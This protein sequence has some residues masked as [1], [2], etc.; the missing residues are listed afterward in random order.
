MIEIRNYRQDDENSWLRCR[1]LSYLDSAY[2]DDVQTRKERFK[3]PVIDLVAVDDDKVIGLIEIECESKPGEYC[4]KGP[5]PAAMIWNILVH[6][7]YRRHGLGT[8]LLNKAKQRALEKGIVR[9]E[10]YTRDDDWVLA[11]YRKNG[12]RQVMSYLHVYMD[13][14]ELGDQ[15][16][17]DT[18][19]LKL[20]HAFAHYTG[21]DKQA[22]CNKY[23]RVHTCTLFE[24]ML[25][26]DKKNES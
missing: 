21:D 19:G 6:P 15:R 25:E 12:W 26:D 11:W 2:Y 5:D 9:F 3:N 13:F 7:D 17:T 10:A 20:I 4:Q 1:V 24:L 8:R 22:I 14:D 16:N 23:K 18:P